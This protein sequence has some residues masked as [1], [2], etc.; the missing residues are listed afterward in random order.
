[1][2]GERRLKGRSVMVMGHVQ[3]DDGQHHEDECLQGN[4]QDVE[5]GPPKLQ[6]AAAEAHGDIVAIHERDEDEDHLA[7]IEV[8]EQS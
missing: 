5:D 2:V 6:E 8:S 4:D 3:I 1:M 7:G